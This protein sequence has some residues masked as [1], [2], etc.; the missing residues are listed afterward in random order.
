MTE[1]SSRY[2]VSTSRSVDGLKR[3]SVRGSVVAVSAQVAKLTLQMATVMVLARLLS[4]EDF[5]LQGMAVILTGFLGIFR[6]AG[7]SAATVQRLEVTHE[8]I[9]TLFWV[10]MSVGIVLA[11]LTAGL[12]PVLSGFYSEPRLVW[13]TIVSGAAF[14]FNGLAAQHLALLLREMRFTTLATID[15]LSLAVSSAV[16]VSMA[17]LG[18]HYWSLVGMAVAASVT[19]A[20]S[21]WLAIRWI[22]GPPR[23]RSGVLSML[24]FGWM[25]SCNGFVVFLAW[26]IDNILVGRVWG[27][28][29]LGLYGRAYQ[30][31]TL[32][33]QQLMGA[34]GGVAFTAFSRIQNDP[35]RL[36]RSFL[37]AYTLLISFTVPIAICCPLF[38][39]E[40]VRVVLGPK[41]IEAT[42][43]FRLLAPTAVVFALANPLSWVVTSMGLVGRALCISA[44]T[45]PVVIVGVV[46]GLSQGPQGVALGYSVAMA[47]I[48]IPITA[49]AKHGTSITWLDLW[50]AT[51]RPLFSGLLAGATGLVVNFSLG[52]LL[53][54][55]PHL[56]VGLGLVLGVYGWVLLIAMGQ[57]D[58]Y[59]DFLAQV[60]RREGR[61][62]A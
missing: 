12:A 30:L 11:T 32:P 52:G 54:P 25:S 43:I 7:L 50:G 55:I 1:L 23:L 4:A 58:L 46:L 59:V 18:W 49:W 26:N 15:L 42:P 17:L 3:K 41:W 38:A 61:N 16:G 8:Q 39:E 21:A 35:E 60:L 14:V 40:I 28:D 6:D 62:E 47:L 13:I 10:N 44:A 37:R 27:A 19:G 56:F 36:A 9:S 34:V 48:V 29:A 24:H 53:A 2:N 51:K 22:P 45:T 33:V 20:G 31:A 57:K 5:G